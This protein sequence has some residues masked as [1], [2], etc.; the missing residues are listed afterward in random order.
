LFCFTNFLNLH[1]LR[2]LFSFFF[3][4]N[5]VTKGGQKK[6][7][8]RKKEKQNKT[9][10]NKTKQNKTKQNKTWLAPLFLLFL[11][12]LSLCFGFPLHPSSFLAFPS[13]PIYPFLKKKDKK[14]STSCFIPFS[15]S[16]ETF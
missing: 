5:N 2:V 9:K 7:K 11:F 10:Q 13:S 4:I 15:L 14:G 6:K 3:P 1:N 16:D 8:K 12:F